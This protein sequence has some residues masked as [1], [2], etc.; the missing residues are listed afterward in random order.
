MTT[1]KN[2]HLVCSGTKNISSQAIQFFD[3]LGSSTPEIA[4]PKTF[5]DAWA[6]AGQQA[7][8]IKSPLP[9]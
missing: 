9:L 4:S 8:V 7:L 2:D 1:K 6:G 5:E 3:P